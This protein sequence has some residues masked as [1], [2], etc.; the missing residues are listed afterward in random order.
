MKL[1]WQFRTFLMFTFLTLIL[2]IFGIFIDMMMA[3]NTWSNIGI[4][5]GISLLV[6]FVSYYKSKD[7]AIRFANARIISE[8]ENPRLFG[9]VRDVVDKAGLPMPQI[10][11]APTTMP[12]AFAT[13]RNPQNAAVVF[14]EGILTLLPDDELKGVIAHEISHIKNRDILVMS[15]AA[16]L[17]S[18]ISYISRMAWWSL[19]LSNKDDRN[20]TTLA[21]ASVAQI[22]VPIAAI[23]IQLGISRS[24]E[25]FADK[26]GAEIIN[27]P[28][29]LA[30][31]LARLENSS[32][33]ENTFSKNSGTSSFVNNYNYA[34]MWIANPLKRNSIFAAIF[35]T[36]P[37]MQERIDRLNKL[38][39]QLGL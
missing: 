26:T 27:N 18:I 30:R 31:A 22:L 21:I 38:A 39:D 5:V 29:A 3:P 9:I 1:W 28:R 10:G 4:V 32:M 34:H 6:C 33:S 7:M 36:H 12:N 37:P 17:S 35:S 20:A 23:I 8:Y 16:A 14:T 13:G 2:V 11:I 24:R 19:F 15:I 25:Y